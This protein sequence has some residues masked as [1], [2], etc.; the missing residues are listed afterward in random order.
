MEKKIEYVFAL[1]LLIGVII[2]ILGFFSLITHIIVSGKWK[3]ITYEWWEIEQGM[4]ARTLQGTHF[5]FYFMLSGIFISLA[6]N[7]LAVAE[8]LLKRYEFPDKK[9]EYVFAVI[10]LIG[11]IFTI[12][13]FFSL[14]NH[15]LV[16]GKWNY[17]IHEWWEVEEGMDASTLQGTHFWF[18]FMFSGIIIS[19]AGNCLAIARILIKKES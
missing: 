5:W 4:N 11:V 10:L 19:F 16:E 9:I 6:G 2:T 14:I 17:I 3:L 8:L 12:L 7:C 15:L 1:I 18:Y 13:G